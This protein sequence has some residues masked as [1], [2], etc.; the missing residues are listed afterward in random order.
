VVFDR[1]WDLELLHFI[2]LVVLKKYG[3]EIRGTYSL[4]GASVS[5]ICYFFTTVLPLFSLFYHCFTIIRICHYGLHI[6][7]VCHCR[8]YRLYEN[9][10][11]EGVNI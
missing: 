1:Q 10:H 6:G 2:L 9:Q 8:I 4:T 5:V 11:M 3:V 7:A